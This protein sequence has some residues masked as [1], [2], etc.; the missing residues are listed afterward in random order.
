MTASKAWAR[1]LDYTRRAA[2]S[3]LPQLIPL[4]ADRF[5]DS[6]AL[7]GADDSI[8]YRELDARTKRYARWA[9]G[10]GLKAGDVVCLLMPNKP[11][12]VTLW[13]GLTRI[14]CTVA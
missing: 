12:Y 2:G 1:A 5:G 11:D 6:P 3:T 9:I 4:L 10:E 7:V 14:G 13:L 8:S